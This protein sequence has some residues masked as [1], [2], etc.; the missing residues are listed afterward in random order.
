[1]VSTSQSRLVICVENAHAIF[2][3]QNGPS[4]QSQKSS[5]FMWGGS[6]SNVGYKR[7]E[8]WG[9][10]VEKEIFDKDSKAY[11]ETGVVMGGTAQGGIKDVGGV[12][13]SGKVAVKGSVGTRYDKSSIAEGKQRLLGPSGGL[14]STYAYSGRGDAQK[15]IGR[16]VYL[17]EPSFEGQVGMFKVNGKLKFVW[18]GDPKKVKNAGLDEFQGEI[19]GL[20]SLPIHQGVLG[21]APA[22]LAGYLN[23]LAQSYRKASIDQSGKNGQALGQALGIGEDMAIAGV[24][25]AQVPAT[26]FVAFKPGKSLNDQMGLSGSKAEISLK[27]SAKYK[28]KAPSDPTK[29]GTNSLEIFLDY[30]KSGSLQY[31]DKLLSAQQNAVDIFSLKQETT[32][33]LL[34]LKWETGKDFAVNPE[35]D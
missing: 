34:T 7:A 21:G 30:V 29:P 17:L 16:S 11:V 19:S 24:Q 1:M 10:N 5:N 9:A 27:A 2:S 14:G 28:W 26:Q 20:A 12:G 15:S 31:V 6:T 18:L 33:R 3:T 25:L 35:L 13:L 4:I 32:S 8:R 23:T 22:L